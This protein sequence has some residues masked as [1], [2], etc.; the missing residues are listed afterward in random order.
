MLIACGLILM[1][2]APIAQ[3][4]T[5]EEPV[6]TREY[7]GSQECAAC[8][9]DLVRFHAG[10]PHALAL[11]H[12]EADPSALLADFSTGE[13]VRSVTLP[14]EDAPRPFT[15]GDISHAIGSG[16]YAQRYLYRL[17]DGTYMVLPAEWNALT[18][19]WQPFTLSETWPDPAYDWTTQCAYCHT[20][21]LNV[22]QGTWAEDG[23]QCEACHGP[24]SE[25]LDAGEATEP[26][27]T[28]RER[29]ALNAS[30]ELGLDPAT[31]GQCHSQ[32][33]EPQHGYPFPLD[34]Q[35]GD[36]LLDRAVFDLVSERSRVHWWQTGQ[37][38]QPNM[39]FNE[40]LTTAHAEAFLTVAQHPHFTPGCLTC[41]NGT[42]SRAAQ[43]VARMEASDDRERIDLL[44]DEA[45]LDIGNIYRIEWDTLKALTLEA[46][47]VDPALI[48]TEQPFLP[49]ILPDLIARMH[50]EDELA[51]GR[52]LPQSLAEVLQIAEEGTND[53]HTNQA[54]GVTCAT[55]HNPHRTAGSPASLVSEVDTLCTGCHRSAEPIYGLHHPV[56]QVFEGQ[57]LIAGVQGVASNHFTAEDG[58]TCATCHMPQ[59][60]VESATRS[61]HTLA[62]VLPAEAAA[63]GDFA[64]TCAGC[65]GERVEGQT[66]QAL[67]DQIQNDTRARY[68]TVRAS[69]TEASPGWITDT[70]EIIRGDGSWG[71]HNY[72]YTAALL[73]AAERELGL[74]EA[75]APLVLPDIPV[76]VQ[77]PADAPV[78]P[79]ITP[80]GLT[81]PSI[82]LLVLTAGILL[83]SA[84][85][86]LVRGRGE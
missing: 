16:K 9:R 8:H 84:Y 38:A 45:D 80:G 42:F 7:V 81:P 68:E 10:T 77:P 3:A 40:W 49:Q 34:Y 82:I 51:D 15:A 79:A 53:D 17:D 76:P 4:Q 24:G 48:H 11:T 61:S 64:D 54:L 37:A 71:I 74:S 66:M 62:P 12:V 30:I 6:S 39:Q 78:T 52:I 57:P 60:P 2:Y 23:V 69:M 25:H 33:T 20:T 14:G 32:G 50:A 44:Y 63:A 67:I 1:F 47:E 13:S 55:C 41:H 73:S 86:F 70:V 43:I 22:E 28:R 27:L 56:Q 29:T 21:N 85:I 65:H 75:A 18:G 19:E 83:F 35:P 46:L 36:E 5:V 26:V 58:P 59:V 72:A 31:C